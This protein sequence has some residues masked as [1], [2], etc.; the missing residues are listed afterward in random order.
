MV[1]D[2]KYLCAYDG[3]FR[4]GFRG[5]H[6]DIRIKESTWCFLSRPQSPPGAKPSWYNANSI[7]RTLAR[8]RRFN[9]TGSD[10]IETR[11]LSLGRR[12]LSVFKAPARLCGERHYP[13]MAFVKISHS[14]GE[15]NGRV[16]Y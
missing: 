1:A 3:G 6:I 8:Q 10:A 16:F 15:I 9:V 11:L 4:G 5:D 7:S 12:G 2:L 13:A 14:Q